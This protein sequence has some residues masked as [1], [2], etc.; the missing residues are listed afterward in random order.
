MA[1]FPFLGFRYVQTDELTASGERLSSGLVP[2]AKG[3]IPGMT[4]TFL[5]K[6]VLRSTRALIRS[7]FQQPAI[8]WVELMPLA[9]EC[10]VAAC[11]DSRMEAHRQHGLKFGSSSLLT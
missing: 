3:V 5:R 11:A 1:V 2:L 4:L 8:S 10:R 9:V 7:Q 6:P